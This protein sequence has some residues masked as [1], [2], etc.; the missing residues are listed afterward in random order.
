MNEGAVFEEIAR[1]ERR[2]RLPERFYLGLLEESDWGFVIKLHSLFEG[3]ATHVLNLRIGSGKLESAISY[4]DFGNT[5]C[6]KCRL[7]LDLGI[8]SKEQYTFLRQLSELRNLLVHQIQ[9]VT[10]SF[11]T[12]FGSLDNNQ[13]K[14]F[15]DQI[16]YSTRDQIAIQDL[17]IPRNQ[18]IREN[19]KLAIWL[20]AADILGCLLLEEQLVA[21]EAQKLQT[22][23]L[24]FACR[25]DELSFLK[26]IASKSSQ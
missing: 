20:T 8:L 24:A 23:E 18:F 19:A 15:C 16:G 25:I 4:L 5:K 10:F 6:G 14:S 21:L 1:F 11:Q 13:F 3:A 7:L 26:S 2:L 9:N 12:Y 22:L 17:T